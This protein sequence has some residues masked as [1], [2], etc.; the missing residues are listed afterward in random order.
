VNFN[1]LLFDF[2]S[3]CELFSALIVGLLNDS[4]FLLSVLYLSVID[5]ENIKYFVALSFSSALDTFFVRQTDLS[6][7]DGAFDSS[8]S[9]VLSHLSLTY[10]EVYGART[11][12]CHFIVTSP[13]LY[14]YPI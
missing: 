9:C 3:S 2:S 14:L 5:L 11:A 4:K 12:F 10:R 13:S 6:T 1:I 8:M 7:R